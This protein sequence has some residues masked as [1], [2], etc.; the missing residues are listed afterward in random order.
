M[1]LGEGERKQDGAAAVGAVAAAAIGLI[2][3]AAGGATAVGAT[4]GDTVGKDVPRGEKTKQE[5]RQRGGCSARG[6]ANQKERRKR[7]RRWRLV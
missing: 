6:A 2:A 1:V 7:E 3:G 5:R 4:A